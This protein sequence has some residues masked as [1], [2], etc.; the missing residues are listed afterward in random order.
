MQLAVVLFATN[1]SRER[2]SG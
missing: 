2:M 1:K